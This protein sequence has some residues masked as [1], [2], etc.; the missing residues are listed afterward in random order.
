LHGRQPAFEAALQGF[1]NSSHKADIEAIN[2][3]PVLKKH[4]ETLKKI[5]ENFV[6]TGSY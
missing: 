4:A 3:E 1:A 6:K 2:A 5:V